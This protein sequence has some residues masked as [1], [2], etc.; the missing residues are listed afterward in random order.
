ML[1]RLLL[2]TVSGLV[3]AASAAE[4][5]VV[6][7]EVLRTQKPAFE[8][9]RFGEI[10]AYEKIVARVKLAVKPDDP[11]NAGIVDLDQ[12][13]KNAAGEV[14]AS[15][16]VYILKPVDPAKGN[17]KLFYDVLNRGRKLGLQLVNDAPASNDPTTAAEVGNG[18]LMERGYTLV[19]S[20]WQGDVASQGDLIGLDLPVVAGVTGPSREE[21]VF[22]DT[23]NP[24]TGNLTYPA[25]DLDPAKATLTVRAR[26]WEER[27]TPAGLSF[28]YASPTRIEITRPQ[29]F[30]ASAIY[31]LIYPA[32]DPKP[33]GLGFAATRDVVSFLRYEKAAPNGTPNPLAV[34]GHAALARAY[35]L[36]ISQSGRFLRDFLYQG[37]NEDEAGRRVFDGLI[38]HIAGSRKTFVNYRFAQP[39]RYSRDHEDHLYPGDEFP[40]TYA[41]STDPLSQATD[42]ILERCA[43]TKDGCPKVIHTDTDTENFQARISLVATD[44]AGNHLDLPPEVRAFFLAGLPH[45][46]SATD[47][48]GPTPT[49]KLPSNPLHAGGAMRALLTALDAWVSEGVEPPA[50][51]YPSARDGTLVPAKD[52]GYERLPG[53]RY[54][55]EINEKPLVDHGKMPPVIVAQYP[56][57]IAKVDGDFHAVAA[58]RLPAVEAPVATYLGWNLRKTGFAEGAI[59]GLTGSTVPLA[60]TKAERE[61][62]KDPRPS[63]EERYPTHAAYVEAVKAAADGLVRDRLLLPADAARI[64][65]EAEAADIGRPKS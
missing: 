48:A 52:A 57:S 15:T 42:G 14:E 23:K 55:A 20:G 65:E 43:E 44:A 49:C 62:T 27:A 50:S 58:L 29:G 30:D 18:F 17:G 32:K 2:A 36:G 1:R 5:R 33:M 64:V 60:R 37:F 22:D 6:E 34:E 39:G 56:V 38:P 53:L 46:V 3:L 4:A 41:V 8:G 26:E 11:R 16:L 51:R 54:Q 19:W 31:E 7:L 45:F 35:A 28:R 13:P 63:L 9:R 10:G 25:A 24:A 59:C 12:A 47:K 21:F 61:A 40:F